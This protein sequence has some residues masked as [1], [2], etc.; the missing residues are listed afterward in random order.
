MARIPLACMTILLAAGMVPAG[1][2]QINTKG[3]RIFSCSH[4][5]HW[6]VYDLLPEMA[7]A[8][9]IK[10]HVNAGI[11]KIGG[12]RI[13]Q[14]WDV[15]GKANEAKQLLTAGKIDVLMLGPI[16]MPDDGIEKFAKL[17]V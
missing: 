14:H 4:S 6:F 1:E 2:A 15:V 9:G 13:R 7:E 3:E 8:A 5:F 16:W 12:S 10:D 11:S 17:A